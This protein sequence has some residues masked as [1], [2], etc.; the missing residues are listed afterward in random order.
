MKGKDRSNGAGPEPRARQFGTPKVR[1]HADRRHFG[2]FQAVTRAKGRVEQGRGIGAVPD[3][4]RSS[5]RTAGE[6]L[7]RLA[8]RRLA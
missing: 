8:E 3:P 4:R 6:D 5:L 1:R 2:A 7:S